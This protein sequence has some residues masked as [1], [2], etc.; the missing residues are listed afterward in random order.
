MDFWVFLSDVFSPEGF[1]LA[2]GSPGIMR[3]NAKKKKKGNKKAYVAHTNAT[4]MK[5]PVQYH[6]R[7]ASD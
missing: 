2:W 1:V 6:A 4:N 3:V 7:Q 5:I